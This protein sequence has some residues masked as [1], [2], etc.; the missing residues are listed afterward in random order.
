MFGDD[1]KLSELALGLVAAGRLYQQ[2]ELLGDGARLELDLNSIRIEAD[3]PRPATQVVLT[4]KGIAGW[5]GRLKQPPELALLRRRCAHA[6]LQWRGFRTARP[7]P[8]AACIAFGEAPNLGYQVVHQADCEPELGCG[9][10]FLE[11][12]HARGTLVHYGVDFA[13]PRLQSAP[14]GRVLWWHDNLPLDLS[15]SRLVRGTELEV[16]K[17]ELADTIV[18]A[19]IEAAQTSNRELDVARDWLRVALAGE[20]PGGHQLI[21]NCENAVSAQRYEEALFFARTACEIDKMNLP[22][23]AMC[24]ALTGDCAA[25]LALYEEALKHRPDDSWVYGNYAED[26]ALCGHPAEAKS[27]IEKALELD[28]K[29]AHAWALKA[30]LWAQESPN[31]ALR[32]ARHATTLDNVPASVWETIAHLCLAAGD[33]SCARS[34]LKKFL[35]QARPDTVWENDLQARLEQAGK[36]LKQLGDGPT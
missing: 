19:A 27:N 11:E 16:W 1:F 34:A 24:T 22:W 13:I 2:V 28:S 36:L 30:K 31:E 10:F 5:L 4:R 23:L 25:S 12:T 6:R 8:E 18:T 29:N 17:G 32:W 33:L 9:Y 21:V 20:A 35:F 14:P 7:K 3:P 26:L 15:R